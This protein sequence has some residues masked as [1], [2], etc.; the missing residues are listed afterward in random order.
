MFVIESAYICVLHPI[1]AEHI[2]YV[3]LVKI[4]LTLL[5][6]PSL[7]LSSF[8]QNITINM[9]KSI[10]LYIGD[11]IICRLPFIIVAASIP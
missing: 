7:T 11:S 3:N 1:L 8:L 4:Q 9:Y 5:R 2:L 6:I 10:I